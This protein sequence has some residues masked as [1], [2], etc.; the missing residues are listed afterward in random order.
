MDISIL[1][2]GLIMG[3]AIAAPIGPIAIL[4]IK[5][6]LSNGR[7]SGF[8]T[9]LGAASAD[10]IYA[11]ISAFGLTIISSFLIKNKTL[12][13]VI[14]LIFLIYLGIKIFFEKSKEYKNSIVSKKNLFFDYFSSLGLTLSNPMT[15][16]AFIAVFAGIGIA[17]PNY[18]LSSSLVVLGVFL[19][20]IIW[21]IILSNLVVIFKRRLDAHSMRIINKLSGLIIILFSLWI[22]IDMI[23]NY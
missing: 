16:L 11:L 3:F 5:R 10:G 12:I 9:G 21:W 7:L 23:K 14:G 4:C 6:S 1:L 2:K 19:G 20:S 22:I 17:N 18:Y 13:Q 15:I 8:L